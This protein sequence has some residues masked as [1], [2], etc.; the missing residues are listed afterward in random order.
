MPLE[1][2]PTDP[3]LA[4][5]VLV[6]GRRSHGPGCVTD[7]RNGMRRAMLAAGACL[8]SIAVLAMTAAAFGHSPA[9]V[10]R[11]LF[12]GSVGS[13]FAIEGTLLKMAPLLLT[14]LSVV[15]AFRAGAWNIGAE[16][17]FIAG[18]IDRVMKALPSALS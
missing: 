7:G 3:K 2:E 6:A 13:R 18:A 9:L 5:I 8:A 17:Q 10:L 12:E 15:I 11:T 4:K 14:G 16:G 1:K